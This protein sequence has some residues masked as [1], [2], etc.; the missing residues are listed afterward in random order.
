MIPAQDL[1]SLSVTEL[2]QVLTDAGSAQRPTVFHRLMDVYC[3]VKAGGVAAQIAIAQRLEATESASLLAELET[4]AQQPDQASR[5]AAVQ[6]E[7]AELS[8]AMR[9]RVQFLSTIS[10]Q[11]E[12]FVQTHLTEI[13]AFLRSRQSRP[14]P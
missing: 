9:H 2:R 14:A 13:E 3:V 11:E 5:R 8:R 1:R 7:L 12:A 6:W 4:L 10:P